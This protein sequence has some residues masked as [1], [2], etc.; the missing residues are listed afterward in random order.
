VKQI[1]ATEYVGGNAV[2]ESN[3][4]NFWGNEHFWLTNQNPNY[5]ADGGGWIPLWD[6]NL[7]AAAAG[8]EVSMGVD[9]TGR[10]M[11]YAC[12]SMDAIFTAYE[13]NLRINV[14]RCQSSFWGC[15]A[16]TWALNWEGACGAVANG[17]G[18]CLWF[19]SGSTRCSDYEQPAYLPCN[20]Q[21]QYHPFVGNAT[22][23]GGEDDLCNRPRQN[24]T[25][26]RYDTNE[27]EWVW[28]GDFSIQVCR[29]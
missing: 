29:P 12:A 22:L 14:K 11:Q 26:S 27:A 28:S 19:S 4:N 6:G 15:P 9:S 24:L 7:T 10:E 20:N 16:P 8:G 1:C 23:E 21:E 25:L 18:D 5:D 2:T 3:V 17:K 13:G